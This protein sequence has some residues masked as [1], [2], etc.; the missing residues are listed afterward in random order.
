MKMSDE[1]RELEL[2]ITN[3]GQLYK[4]Q[5]VPIIRNL[6][7]KAAAGKYDREMAVKLFMYLVDAGGK[8]YHKEQG[9]GQGAW[10]KM[11]PKSART[12]VAK[13][14]RDDFE[15]E[16]RE[17]NYDEYIPKKYKGQKIK[18]ESVEGSSDGSIFTEDTRKAIIAIAEGSES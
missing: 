13:S 14:L 6:M 9:A 16:A 15:T 7:R 17:G 18:W 11:F 12:E 3:D 4:S 5:H 1:A 10:H 8:K 2:F